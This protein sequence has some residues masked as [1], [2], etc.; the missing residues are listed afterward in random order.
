MTRDEAS[1]KIKAMGGKVAGSVSAKTSYVV[2][3]DAAGSK[4][5]KARALGVT[6]IDEDELVKMLGQ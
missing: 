3:G 5:T 4:L 1:E 6:V 2:A